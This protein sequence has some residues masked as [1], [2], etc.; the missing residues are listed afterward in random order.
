MSNS[1]RPNRPSAAAAKGATK[2]VSRKTPRTSQVAVVLIALFCVAA[3]VGIPLLLNNKDATTPAGSGAVS[4]N[5]SPASV[6]DVT[7]DTAPPAVSNPP[8][9]NTPPDPGLAESSTWEATLHTTCGDIRLQLDGQAA[10][11]TVASFI[12]LAR[13][14]YWKDSPCHRLTTAAT[15]IFVL[16][17]GDPTGSGSG[18]PGYGFGI[19]NAPADGQYPR[20]TLAMARGQDPNSNGGQFFIVYKDTQLPTGGGGY[21]IFGK[22]SEGMQIVDAIVNQGVEDKQSDGAPFQPISILSVDV[23]KKG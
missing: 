9:T 1:K 17:C 22:V 7:C 14:S 5:P 6:A 18:S 13:S 11:Q 10:P 21:T 4:S 19:E 16:Q 8:Q 3:V 12:S 20:G 2:G 15:G 23:E